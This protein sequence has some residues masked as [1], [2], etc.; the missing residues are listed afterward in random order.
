M[1]NFEYI[2]SMNEDQFVDFMQEVNLDKCWCPNKSNC[3]LYN[4][5]DDAF[6]AWLKS[7]YV[8]SEFLC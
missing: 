4:S 5:C 6:V 3:A 1:T 8:K 7:E 2:K